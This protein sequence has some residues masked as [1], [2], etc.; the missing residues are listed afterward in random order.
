MAEFYYYEMTDETTNLI[1]EREHYVID[2]APEADEAKVPVAKGPREEPADVV[3][4]QS[5]LMTVL[6]M[7]VH[8]MVAHTLWHATVFVY[9]HMPRPKP[10]VIV[11]LSIFILLFALLARRIVANAEL[12]QDMWKKSGSVF[13]R[14]SA[15]ALAQVE[16]DEQAVPLQFAGEDKRTRK[17]KHREPYLCTVVQEVKNRFGIPLDNTANRLAVRKAALDI[18]TAHQVRPTHI[19]QWIDTVVELVFI[20]NDSE[21]YSQRVANS[22]RALQ[23]RNGYV[24]GSLQWV[25]RIFHFMSDEAISVEEA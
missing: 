3:V 15:V 18:M 22:L 1:P 11:V 8:V 14:S 19:N 23:R 10:W 17:I 5:L 7:I 13:R 25:S 12:E 9:Y 24:R 6:N 20:P 16:E 4:R 2:I 21:V